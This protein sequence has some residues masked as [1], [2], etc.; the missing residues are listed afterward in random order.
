[1]YAIGGVNFFCSPPHPLSLF[2]FLDEKD[3]HGSQKIWVSSGH[4]ANACREFPAVLMPKI[5]STTN[6]FELPV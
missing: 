3:L 2:F 6:T 5:F 1:M 4:H